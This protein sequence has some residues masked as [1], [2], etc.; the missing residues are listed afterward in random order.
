MSSQPSYRVLITDYV[1]PNLDVEQDVLAEAGAEVVAAATGEE[2]ELRSLAPGMDAIIT[3]F[4][5]VSADTIA[6]ATDCL[7]VSRYGV[8]LDNID[9]ETATS[10]GILV[11]NVPDYCVDEVSDHAMALLL[12]AARRVM[13]YDRSVRAGAW[14]SAVGMPLPRVRGLTLGI[15]GYGRIGRAVA[16]KA[17]AFGLRLLVHDPL[18]EPE[19]IEEDGATPVSLEDLL[20][21]SDFVTVHAPLVPATRNLLD[22]EAFRVMRPTAWLVNTARGGI[23]DT[24]A[25]AQALRE[26]QLAG[27]ALDVLPDEPPDTEEALRSLPNVILTPHISFYSEGSLEEL[28][29]RASRHVVQVLRGEIPTNLVNPS[30]LGEPDL[31]ARLRRV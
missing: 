7:I 14:D 13:I 8:G 25:L 6:A 11:T 22:E 16:G 24:T 17:R 30:V 1:W 18:V 5:R 15:I 27:A 4:K 28:R 3:C 26:G 19:V 9:V 10:L 12:C 23:V 21:E 20:R 2:E 29:F 31:R